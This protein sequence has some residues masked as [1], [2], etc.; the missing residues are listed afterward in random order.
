MFPHRVRKFRRKAI[1][2]ID[3]LAVTHGS[4]WLRLGL[5]DQDADEYILELASGIFSLALFA[6]TIYAWNRRGR[7]PTLLLVALAFFTFFLKQVLE[8]IPLN[9]AN[10][11]LLSSLLDFLALGLFFAAL[12][13]R[14]RRQRVPSGEGTSEKSAPIQNSKGTS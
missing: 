13:V 7:T 4:Y 6:L 14:P 11:E 1:K 8:V 12:V 10:G 2:M 3:F 9:F 5:A